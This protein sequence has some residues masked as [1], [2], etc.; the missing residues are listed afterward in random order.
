MEDLAGRYI[1]LPTGLVRKIRTKRQVEAVAG[2][3]DTRTAQTGF[4]LLLSFNSDKSA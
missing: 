4:L 1:P 3:N 2:L